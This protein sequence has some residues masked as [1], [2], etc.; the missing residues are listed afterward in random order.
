[1]LTFDVYPVCLDESDAHS[2]ASASPDPPDGLHYEYKWTDDSDG[3]VV[4]VVSNIYGLKRNHSYTINV[5]YASEY[6]RCNWNFS[7]TIPDLG[8]IIYF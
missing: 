4:G 5:A 3:S 8:I 2:K 1:M 7:V 6:Q